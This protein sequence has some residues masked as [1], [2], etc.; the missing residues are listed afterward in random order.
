ME[1]VYPTHIRGGNR[2]YLRDVDGNNFIDYICGLGTNLFGYGNPL[3]ERAVSA[4]LRQGSSV[5]SLASIEEVEYAEKV[6]SI[7]PFLDR[8]RFLKTGSEGCS[9]AVRIARAFTGKPYVFVEGYN[10]WHDQFVQLTPP[11]YGVATSEDT[12]KY[13]PNIFDRLKDS[14]AAVIVE[15][16]MVDDT[17]KRIK[18]LNELR[19]KCT[20]TGTLLIF[21]ETITAFRYA[22][23]SVTKKHNIIPDLWVGGKAVG[24]GLPLSIVGGRKDVMEAD[25][26]VS[27][28][29]GGDR[30]AFAAGS[31]A[32]DM[33]YNDY[34]CDTTWIFGQEF[35]DKFN[36]ISPFVQLKGYATRGVF[37]YTHD[38]FKALFMQE[39]CRAGVLIGPSWFYNRDLHAE[40]DNVLSIAKG[41]IKR[42]VNNEVSLKGKVPRSPFAEQVRERAQNAN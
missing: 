28:T 7:F 27:S 18:F 21:D 37:A 35:K 41:A 17:E 26:F 38:M 23:H 31:A 39:L 6:Q 22:E 12:F 34:K 19:E 13:S 30:L 40:M 20:K 8:V 9:A 4:A 32:I 15:P 2:C 3:I 14:T 5:Y 10:G 33:L 25:Y 1:G 11:A 36:D 24:G 42:I 29:W 16:V